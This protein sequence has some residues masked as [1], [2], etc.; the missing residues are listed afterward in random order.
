MSINF[1]VIASALRQK[2]LSGA[3]ITAED[4][5]QMAEAARA[6]QRLDDRVLYA[7]LKSKAQE[8]EGAAE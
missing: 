4:V 5:T 8:N 6:T 7:A 2:F 3:P 1:N